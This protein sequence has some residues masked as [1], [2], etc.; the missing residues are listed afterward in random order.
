MGKVSKALNKAGTSQRA[1][2]TQPEPPP[3]VEHPKPSFEP[4]V[5]SK[6]PKNAKNVE[7]K[8]ELNIISPAP[9]KGS[10]R[11]WDERLIFAT[12]N[13]S[14]VKESFK[15]LRTLIM[16]P[17]SGKPPSKIMVLS[18]DPQEGKSFVCANLGV[19]FAQSLEKHALMV[20]CDLRRPSLHTLF[21]ISGTKGLANHLGKGED[22]S[23][24]IFHTGLS[25]LSLLPAGKPPKNP[26]EL[27]S[28]EKMSFVLDELTNRYDDRLILLDSPPFHAAS[29]TL[30]LSHLVDKVVIVVRWGKSGRENIKKMVD[31][32]GRDRII[33]IVFNAFEM[34][35]L[36][37][38]VQGVGYHNYYSE[39]Y[40]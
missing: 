7:S 9:P 14:G 24:L 32:I 39:T 27:L 15:K 33:G 4:P 23:N 28:S 1:E 17:E 25:K 8:R 26:S 13:F 22:I 40:Y 10:T 30:V 29:E 37:K 11:N 20:D 18:S 36:D 12:E 31:V 19:N 34:N 3:A 21:G 2:H 6:P 38:K 35:I 16:H 5:I